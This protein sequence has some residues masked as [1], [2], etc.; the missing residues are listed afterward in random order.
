[1]AFSDSPTYLLKSSGPLIAMKFSLLSVAIALAIIVFEQPGGP[2]SK[3][4]L[5]GFIPIRS[6]ASGCFSG[7]SITFLISDLTDSYPPISLQKT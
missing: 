6:K 1:M 2:Y 4:P 7:H 3:T 5:E